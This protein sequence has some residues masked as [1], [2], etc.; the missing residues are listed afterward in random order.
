MPGCTVPSHAPNE[1][2]CDG[3]RNLL[4]R[5]ESGELQS[6]IGAGFTAD[7]MRMAAWFDFNVNVYETLG[8]LAW[9]QAEYVHRHTEALA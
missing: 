7:G 5:A 4:E 9:L 6:M 2:L 3:L 8:S 1:A